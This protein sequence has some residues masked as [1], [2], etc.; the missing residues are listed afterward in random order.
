MAILVSW[1]IYRKTNEITF[2]WMQQLAI[3]AENTFVV[4]TFGAHFH[5]QHGSRNSPEFSINDA[6]VSF[7]A[8]SKFSTDIYPKS[9]HTSLLSA[10]TSV[11]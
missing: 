3:L 8:S 6:K 10:F 1:N 2:E 11:N 7:T 5:T 4:R 9:E